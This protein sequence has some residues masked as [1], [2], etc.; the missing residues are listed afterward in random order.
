MAIRM[1]RPDYDL[2][3]H[4]DEYLDELD[5]LM[6]MTRE[7]VKEMCRQSSGH[8]RK[9]VSGYRGVFTT[10]YGKWGAHIR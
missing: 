7:E 5:K 3:F 6:S 1:E 2:N 9:S 8:K 4:Y 10:T